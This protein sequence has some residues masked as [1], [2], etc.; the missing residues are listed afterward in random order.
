VTLSDATCWF[1]DLLSGF[2]SQE[3]DD[4]EPSS[5][6]FSVSMAEM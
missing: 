3:A 1:G 5:R 4:I 2:L 6:P